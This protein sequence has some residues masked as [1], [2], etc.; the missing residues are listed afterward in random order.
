MPRKLQVWGTLVTRY[1]H[2]Y[3]TT[4]HGQVRAVVAARSRAEAARLL[5]I[6]DVKLKTYGSITH[7]KKEMEAALSKPG[8]VFLSS[9]YLNPH[10][11]SENFLEDSV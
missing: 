1:G 4:H 9:L 7:N 8:T 2:R 6:K 11:L 3:A 10:T 5:K